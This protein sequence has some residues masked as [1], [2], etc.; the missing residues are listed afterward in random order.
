MPSWT[1][2]RKVVL[3]MTIDESIQRINR[4]QQ[5]LSRTLEPV[6]NQI[7]RAMSPIQNQ[8]SQ[9][10]API[11]E[12]QQRIENSVAPIINHLN[13]ISLN[14]SFQTLIS[15]QQ[16]I[17][18]TISKL[19]FDISSSHISTEASIEFSQIVSDILDEFNDVEITECT[20]SSQEISTCSSQKTPLTWERILNIIVAILTIISFAQD[21]LPDS[22]S[23]N[24]E[25]AIYQIIEFEKQQ[26]N[27]LEE[28]INE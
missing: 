21:Q 10:M 8:I 28:L 17:L 1:I 15:S 26:L 19:D 27:L 4:L 11:I 9:A 14:S 3:V 18:N 6:Q 7:S 24:M 23:I 25:K 13:S 22:H 5:Q 20:D 16:D 2:K 12:Q